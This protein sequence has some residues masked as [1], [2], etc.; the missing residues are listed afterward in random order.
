M[1]A[2]VI[3][4]GSDV[5]SKKHSDSHQKSGKRVEDITEDRRD[6]NDSRGKKRTRTSGHVSDLHHHDDKYHHG[7]GR[8]RD[9][10]KVRRNEPTEAKKQSVQAASREEHWLSSNLR[11]KVVDRTYKNGRHYNTKVRELNVQGSLL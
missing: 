10:K 11:V 1:F 2:V 3:L 4:S 7:G 5:K 6:V 8:D 9:T